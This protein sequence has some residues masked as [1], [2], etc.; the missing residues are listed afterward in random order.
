MTKTIIF[1]PDK[2][3]C[4]TEKLDKSGK[5]V[6]QEKTI[7]T[8]GI[9]RATELVTMNEAGSARPKREIELVFQRENG[10]Y[11]TARM[12][13]SELTDSTKFMNAINHLD[14][15]VSATRDELGLFRR[16]LLKYRCFS[17]CTQ[18]WC[19]GILE[20]GGHLVYVDRNGFVA[21]DD[22]N[23]NPGM[24]SDIRAPY[25]D[26]TGIFDVSEESVKEA[27]ARLHTYG[28]LDRCAAIIGFA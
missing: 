13:I 14:I 7:I 22:K 21:A 25:R 3:I 20:Q 1:E 18:Q 10:E 26:L 23:W 9:A 4:E 28:P 11:H 5:T 8:A 6:T 16:S 12:D 2:V 17:S 19:S 24:V 27:I 15:V